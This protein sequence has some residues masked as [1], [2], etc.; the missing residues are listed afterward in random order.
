M[1]RAAI[2]MHVHCRVEKKA[3]QAQVVSV[4][5]KRRWSFGGQ[6]QATSV[7]TTTTPRIRLPRL[8]TI[9]ETLPT[10]GL[11][12]SEPHSQSAKDISSS[13]IQQKYSALFPLKS[14]MASTPRSTVSQRPLSSAYIQQDFSPFMG[15]LKKNPLNMQSLSFSHLP[16]KDVVPKLTIFDKDILSKLPSSQKSKNK[17]TVSETSIAGVE[18][19]SDSPDNF[20]TKERNVVKRAQS[21]S[22][23][24]KNIAVEKWLEGNPASKQPNQRRRPRSAPGHRSHVKGR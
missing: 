14:S 19:F 6:Q 22:E 20:P 3:Q 21:Y 8:A 16:N 12:K 5:L 1:W 24:N 17:R 7:K 2:E 10:N 23:G 13:N 11:Q 9:A 4:K 15:N 18:I